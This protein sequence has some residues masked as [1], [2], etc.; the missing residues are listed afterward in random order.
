MIKK[1]GC[2]SIKGDLQGDKITKRG[3]FI[4]QAAIGD[5]LLAVRLVELYNNRIDR[6]RWDC[7]GKK[8][9]G[10]LGRSLGIFDHIYDFEDP[11]WLFLFSERLPID[12]EA[13][14]CL[15]IYDVILNFVS[16]EDSIFTRNLKRLTSA[17]IYCIDSRPYCSGIHIYQHLARQLLGYEGDIA[18]PKSY[19]SPVCY[20]GKGHI[21]SKDKVIYIHPGGSSIRK[22]WGIDNFMRLARLL[23]ESFPVRFLLGDVEFEIFGKDI[24]S[25]L[26]ECAQD[27][28]VNMPLD[29]LA[30]VLC[31]SI[32]Y[33]GNDSGIS[34]LAAALG[35]R[36]FVVF[37]GTDPTVWRPLGP[38]V[39][40]FGPHISYKEL[41]SR[42]IESLK[43]HA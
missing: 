28:I 42:I 20:N 41:Y 12:A 4:H 40:V 2:R 9:L 23:G 13:A 19:F 1:E 36:T 35:V 14:R 31:N 34:H 22:C 5:F 15:S 3:L 26:K 32:C 25:V 29:R 18:L 6:L 27:V 38:H 39:E 24:V 33:I 17:Y 10:M 8:S 30:C 16:L 37:V 11:R 43:Q 7:L 21:N